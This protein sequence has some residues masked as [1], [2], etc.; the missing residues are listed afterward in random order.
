MRGVFVTGTDTGVGKTLV[1]ACLVRAWGADYWKPVQTGLDVDEGDTA[2]VARFAQLPA[3]R[4]HAPAYAFGPPLSPH[5]AAER[6]GVEIALDRFTL[7][8]SVRPIVVEGA[9][10]ALVPL[11]GQALMVDLMQALALP[12]VVVAADRLG[13]INHTLMTLETLRTRGLK[14]AGVILTGDPFADNAEAI[15]RH[16]GVKVL[17]RLPRAER[18]DAGVV[19]DWAEHMPPLSSC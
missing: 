15:V 8:A 12:V 16:E 14:V 1:S 10:G 5:L 4:L 11:N 7:P 18:I 19:A 13:A 3:G 9:G 2:A 6:A 17:A